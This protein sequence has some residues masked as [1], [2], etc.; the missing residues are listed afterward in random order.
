MKARRKD[1]KDV[2]VDDEQRI[3]GNRPQTRRLIVTLASELLDTA[4]QLFGPL[5]GGGPPYFGQSSR[6]QGGKRASAM[7]ACDA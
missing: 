2:A 5:Q 4:Q 1:E 7:A 3:D 6:I